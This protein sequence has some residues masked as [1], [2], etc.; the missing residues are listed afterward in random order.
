MHDQQTLTRQIDGREIPL[1]GSYDIDPSHT[2]VEAVARHMMVARIRGRFADF[3]GTIDVAENP[4]DSSATVTIDAASVHTA[5]PR[6]DAHLR[7][8]DFLDAE[9]HPTLTFRTQG[10]RPGPSQAEWLL[11]GELTIRG[12]TRPVTLEARFLGAVIDHRGRHRIMFSAT[13][14]I[15]REDFGL[16]WNQ[17]LEA[18][19]VV[20]GPTLRIELEVQALRR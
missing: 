11:D 5:E 9:N 3:S 20:I 6:R 7:S 17:A 2:S 1:P 18:G 19:G 8:A 14:E 10:L 12:T 16:V 4:V 13:T 15:D